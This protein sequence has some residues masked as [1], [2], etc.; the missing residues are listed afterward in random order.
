MTF[1]KLAV[2]TASVRLTN[3]RLNVHH[4]TWELIRVGHLGADLHKIPR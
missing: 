2:A 1:K 4:V 3:S